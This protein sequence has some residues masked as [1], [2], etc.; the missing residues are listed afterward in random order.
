M[1]SD[2]GFKLTGVA[3]GTG[4]LKVS[5][6]PTLSCTCSRQAGR[7]AW[8]LCIGYAGAQAAALGALCMQW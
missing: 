4:L 2:V 3:E 7:G 8:L 1:G 5:L 6:C